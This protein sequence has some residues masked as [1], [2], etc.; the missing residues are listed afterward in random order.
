MYLTKIMKIKLPVKHLK[1]G[2][3][4][5]K[6]IITI[7]KTILL[8]RQVPKLINYSDQVQNTI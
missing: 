6:K 2:K 7:I 3:L 1:E 4:Q 8:S 5:F